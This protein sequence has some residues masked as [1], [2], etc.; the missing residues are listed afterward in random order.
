MNGRAISHGGYV[1]LLSWGYIG[2][3]KSRMEKKME[4]T[5][6][7]RVWGLPNTKPFQYAIIR[8]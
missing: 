7:F 4:T 2:G 5:I 3:G 8:Y 6:I 1:S